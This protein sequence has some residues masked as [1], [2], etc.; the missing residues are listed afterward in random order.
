MLKASLHSRAPRPSVTRVIWGNHK[1]Y[2]ETY[3]APYP[4]L[5]HVGWRRQGQANIVELIWVGVDVG[6][7]VSPIFPR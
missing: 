1:R 3:M 6:L 2:L 4:G 5:F 7:L